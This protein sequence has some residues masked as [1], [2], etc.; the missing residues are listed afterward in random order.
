MRTRVVFGVIL[1]AIA[2]GV[3]FLLMREPRADRVWDTEVAHTTTASFN[4]D[5]TV[6]LTH[7]RDFTYGDTTVV[8]TDWISAVTINPNDVTAVWFVLEPFPYWEAAGH[9]FLT[10]EL[11]DGSA[12]SF[13]VEARREVG[14]G[15]SALKGLFREYELAYTWGTERDFVTRRLLYLD[16]TVRMYPLALHQEQAERLF[17]GLLQETN[18]IAERPRFY[19]TLTANCTNVLAQIAN[20]IK[21]GTIPWDISWHLP[22]YSDRF[23]IEIGFIETGE[24]VEVVQ[25]EY[26][27]TKN[28][29]SILDIADAPPLEFS[30]E[31]RNYLP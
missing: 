25:N 7:V 29:D 28:R 4:E 20:N 16:H 22:G 11:E 1:I 31:L 23:L 5:G 15:Y 3:F 30:K 8:S 9:T 17:V 14:E 6:T 2:L 21:P 24:S 10:F 13:S 27:L 12:Y 26:D 18:S 19:N